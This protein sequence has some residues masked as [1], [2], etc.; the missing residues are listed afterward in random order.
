ME[1]INSF[2]GNVG[3]L[4]DFCHERMKGSEIPGNWIIANS[5]RRDSIGK[6]L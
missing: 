4:E 6:L 5:F 2:L 1:S 3:K